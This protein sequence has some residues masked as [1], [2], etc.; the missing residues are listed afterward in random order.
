MVTSER[1]GGVRV[2][3]CPQGYLGP[4]YPETLTTLALAA[5]R[6]PRLTW[7][8]RPGR[9]RSLTALSWSSQLV[10]TGPRVIRR[11]DGVRNGWNVSLHGRRDQ[12]LVRRHEGQL[13][14]VLQADRVAVGI[15]AG[16]DVGFPGRPGLRSRWTNWTAVDHPALRA[17]AAERERAADI[18]RRRL[19]PPRPRR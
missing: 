3:R 13:A 2:R 5:T 11:P 8:C 7:W 4:P 14:V 16:S 17:H 6:T 18:T 15:R 9:H 12:R 19:R 1:E 10:T